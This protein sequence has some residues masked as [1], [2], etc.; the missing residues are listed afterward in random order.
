EGGYIM[1]FTSPTLTLADVRRHIPDRVAAA[2]AF[3]E[4]ER[5][6]AQGLAEL[7]VP[8]GYRLV[9]VRRLE[10]ALAE[11]ARPRADV[12]AIVPLRSWCR[13]FW[14]AW[15]K[16]HPEPSHPGTP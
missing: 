3:V 15:R 9:G 8:I 2:A 1:E 12:G 13:I 7:F 5:L 4:L 10:I 16:T 14:D 6:Q 11:E